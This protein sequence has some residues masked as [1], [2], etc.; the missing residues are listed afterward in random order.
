MTMQQP[1]YTF[2]SSNQDQL[3]TKI[4]GLR[5]EAL[6]NKNAN[7]K[8]MSELNDFLTKYKSSSQFKG[9]CSENMLENVLNKMYPCAEIINTTGIKAAGDFTVKREGKQNLII[10]NKLYERN[11]NVDEI[12]KFLRDINEQKTNG[13]MMSQFSGIVSK[14]NFFIEIHDGKVLIYLHNVEY[15]PEKIRLAI[16]V[17]DNLSSK[18]EEISNVE[19]INGCII[20]KDILDKINEQFQLFISQKEVVLTTVKE[21]NK[22]LMNQIEELKMPDLS[23]YLNEKYASIQNQQFACEVCDLPF[24]NK[25]SLAA[26]KKIHKSKFSDENYSENIISIETIQLVQPLMVGDIEIPEIKEI[27]KSPVIV[28][29]KPKREIKKKN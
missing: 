2:L 12:K 15:S 20:K 29:E 5:E 11:V 1:I 24:Q 28:P 17:I 19:E 13:I 14:S 9:Q 27:T 10:E 18:I 7:E 22:K 21:M 26:H 3:N 6:T 4:N 25:R 8:V 16:D 23:L